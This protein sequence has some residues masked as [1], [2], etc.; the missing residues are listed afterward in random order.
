MLPSRVLLGALPEMPLPGPVAAV[1]LCG[2]KS[3]RMG[4]PKP[5]L[6]WGEKTLLEHV[7][8]RICQVPGVEQA[9]LVA[10]PG[11]ELPPLKR[12][13]AVVRDRKPGL[14][15]LEGLAQGLAAARRAG[16][17]VA[18]VA[19]CDVPALQVPFVLCVLEQLREA[20]AAVPVAGGH[21]H[22][23]VAAYRTELASLAEELLEQGHM[24]PRDLLARV[25]TRLLTEDELRR[26]DPELLSLQNANTPE[27]YRR[28]LLALGMPLPAWLQ[29]ASGAGDT[30]AEAS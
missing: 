4:R 22:V 14:G 15:P 3:R 26:A 8:D 27:E 29:S 21:Q 7:V 19:S 1:V 24:R 30:G 10:A 16:C 6:P 23:L 28:L 18:F 2:G 12:P 25:E 9:I 13:V 5:W 17:P 11:Q 20:D